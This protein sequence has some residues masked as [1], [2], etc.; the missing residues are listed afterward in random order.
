MAPKSSNKE[1]SDEQLISKPT[2]SK[3]KGKGNAK[4]GKEAKDLESRKRQKKSEDPPAKAS[5]RHDEPD[6]IELGRTKKRWIYAVEPNNRNEWFDLP[7]DLYDMMERLMFVVPVT[8]VML[9]TSLFLGKH[10]AFECLRSN[11]QKTFDVLP[12]ENNLCSAARTCIL[13]LRDKKIREMGRFIF[14]HVRWFMEDDVA[15]WLERSFRDSANENDQVQPDAPSLDVNVNLRDPA[16]E[17]AFD[18]A[19]RAIKGK[20]NAGPKGAGKVC[21]IALALEYGDHAMEI[22]SENASIQHFVRDN[23]NV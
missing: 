3:V 21:R 4:S 10:D 17:Q 8:E 1:P 5:K 2:V 15:R 19:Q 7:E 14:I 9:P 13:G 6:G 22:R 23:M 12:R 20:G 16:H 11:Y 18:E